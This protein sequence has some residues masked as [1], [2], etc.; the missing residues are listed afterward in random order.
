MG[1]GMRGG[2]EQGVI[3]MGGDRVLWAVVW[4]VGLGLG[5]Y[6]MQGIGLDVGQ[7]IPSVPLNAR[8]HRPIF[9]GFAAESAVESADSISESAIFT[10]D[11]TKVG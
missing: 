10:T 11:F 2:G 8:T 6:I 5:S 7:S 9:R 1:S 3:N 4:G